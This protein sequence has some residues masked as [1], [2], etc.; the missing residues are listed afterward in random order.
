MNYIINYDDIIV[1][2][3]NMDDLIMTI[4]IINGKNTLGNWFI[5]VGWHTL[6]CAYTSLSRCHIKI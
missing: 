3:I 2:Y 4:N 6:Q 1:Y 5:D